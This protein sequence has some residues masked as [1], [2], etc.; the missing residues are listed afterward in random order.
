MDQNRAMNESLSLVLTFALSAGV[1]LLV[2]LERERN[3]SA[4]A[5]VRTF[6]LI[7]VAGTLSALLT[8]CERFSLAAG[9]WRAV[10]RGGSRR[11]VPA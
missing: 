10:H 6:A 4:K 2:G 8:D 11:R 3:P 5:G 1:G 9:G 7:A